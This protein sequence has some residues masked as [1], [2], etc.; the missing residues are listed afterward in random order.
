L[1]FRD[2]AFDTF[3]ASRF[4]EAEVSHMTIPLAINVLRSFGCGGLN[5]F[6][7]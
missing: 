6:L 4:M 5:F 7:Q 2:W 1:A 3:D